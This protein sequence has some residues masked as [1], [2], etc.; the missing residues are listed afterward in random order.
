MDEYKKDYFYQMNWDAKQIREVLA[1]PDLEARRQLRESLS[2][3]PF[4]WYLEHV[5]TIHRTHV[6]C[7]AGRSRRL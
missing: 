6:R 1:A 4:S 5:G 2:C 7:K 3:K